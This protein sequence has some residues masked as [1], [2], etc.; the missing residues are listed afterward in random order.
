MPPN[1]LLFMTDSM[2]GRV[3]RHLG[4]PAAH[5][6]NMDRLAALGTSFSNAYCNSP[7]CA[8][9]RASF[10][11]GQYV[12]RV[13]AWNNPG[14]LPMDAPT[15]GTHLQDAGYGLHVFGKTDYRVGGHSLKAR[16]TAWIRSANIKR[17]H[18]PRPQ[19]TT[20]VSP[21]LHPL[22][23]E[24]QVP[25]SSAETGEGSSGRDLSPATDPRATDSDSE[26]QPLPPSPLR[27]RAGVRV[28]ATPSTH[29][30]VQQPHPPNPSAQHTKIEYLSPDQTPTRLHQ[31]DWLQ[32]DNAC[33][34]LNNYSKDDSPYLLYPSTNVPHPPFRTTRHYL[35]KID[36]AAVTLPPYESDLHP[37]MDYMSVTKNTHGHFT[38]EEILAIR[39]HYFAMV[40][41]TDAMLG[42]VLDTLEAT[43]QLNDTYIIFASDHGE[44]NMEHRQTLKN[45][46]YEA[47][48]RVPLIVAGPGLQQG[49]S[50]DDLVSLIDL[51]P[52]LMDIAGLDHPE[53]LDGV[54]LLP[55]CRG[56]AS[57]RPNYVFSEYHSNF[58]N[59]GIAMWRQGPWKYIRYAGYDPQLFNLD[60][61]PEELTNLAQS[62]PHIVQD[63]DA[64]LESL[65]DFTH[66]DTQAKRNDRHN[67]QTWRQPLTPTEIQEALTKSHQGIWHPD[68]DKR[69][70][71]WLSDS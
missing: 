60:D 59:T 39:R 38:D 12:H 48:A 24:R 19:A 17:P 16:L 49:V 50:S 20:Y 3:M 56:D 65:V 51:F 28:A 66:V 35:D 43:G 46:L 45:A 55:L 58:S 68:D 30:E 29:A 4:H 31:K 54:S 25:A 63:L 64:R 18:N 71:S 47:S 57:K 23:G 40:A 52:T 2:D 41:E 32:I 70:E 14:G 34:F 33:Q 62:H 67:Y 36:P 13:Q 1:I 42:Q 10:W 27:E 26:G 61:D 69:L 7:Q 44:M 15:F 37:V 11:S 6:P 5:T 53:G 22:Q 9:S 8:P 21:N